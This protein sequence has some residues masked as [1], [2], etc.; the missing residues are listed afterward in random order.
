LVGVNVT[1]FRL[2]VDRLKVEG[3]S[4]MFHNLQP[5]FLPIAFLSIIRKLGTRAQLRVG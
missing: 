1:G 2:K 5:P 3:R 4:P